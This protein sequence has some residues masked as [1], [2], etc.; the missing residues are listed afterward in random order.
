[1]KNDYSYRGGRDGDEG[2][3]LIKHI[4]EQAVN[5]ETKAS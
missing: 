4:E 5:E 2:F 1:M 3:G